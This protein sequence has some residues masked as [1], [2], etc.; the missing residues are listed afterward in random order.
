MSL[1]VLQN[2]D[3]LPGHLVRL[4]QELCWLESPLLVEPAQFSLQEIKELRYA[5]NE[6][7]PDGVKH[8]ARV[9]CHADLRQQH[10][11]RGGDVF[12]GQLRGLNDEVVML[13]T[14]YAGKLQLPRA[15]VKS[16]ELRETAALLYRGP[17]RA[18]EWLAE[19]AE[20][21]EFSSQSW[22]NKAS[23]T[24]SRDFVTLP[25]RYRFHFRL[26]WQQQLNVML[27]FALSGKEDEQQSF[28]ALNIDEGTVQMQ[29]EVADAQPGAQGGMMGEPVQLKWFR[30]RQF[31]DLSVAVDTEAGT[32]C[33]MAED[34]VLQQWTD[35]LGAPLKGS[36][37]KFC[38]MNANASDLVV[39]HCVLEAWDGVQATPRDAVDRRIE[40]PEPRPGEQELVLSNGD[41]IV[42]EVQGVEGEMLRLKTRL[43][44]LV[45][46]VGRLRQIALKSAQ[47]EERLLKKGDVRA[48][49]DNGDSITFRIIAVDETGRWRGESQNFGEAW[50]LP[51]AFT[52][53]EFN[54]YPS[55]LPKAFGGTR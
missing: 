48:W 50:F 44:D 2:G 41:I 9:E 28:Y 26:Q 30:N 21:W 23:G 5:A 53:V 52:R 37:W 17:R 36:V 42:A 4:E 54:I 15:M 31:A 51:Q 34:E 24:L 25:P 20:S 39:S 40:V 7:E 13:D 1:L 18:E 43:T 3:Q 47:H 8:R 33:L 29:K 49:F 11:K 12:S 14:A 38:Q 6:A 19:P 16:I 27:R 22:N 32:I 46:P 35:A 55:L 45:L 10:E